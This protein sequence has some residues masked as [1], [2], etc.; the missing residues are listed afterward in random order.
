MGAGHLQSFTNSDQS[1]ED[2]RQRGDK[3]SQSVQRNG[4]F[5]LANEVLFVGYLEPSMSFFFFF[6]FFL[7]YSVQAIDRCLRVGPQQSALHAWPRPALPPPKTLGGVGVCPSITPCYKWHDDACRWL[8]RHFYVHSS[9]PTYQPMSSDPPRVPTAALSHLAAIPGI[10][11]P[12][13]V[14]IR[15]TDEC[16]DQYVGWYIGT[17]G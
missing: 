3:T 4:L 16:T 9:H 7:Q 11:E 10:A 2:R 5:G 14:M 1:L 8:L 6:L 17:I 12:P 13:G 15:S